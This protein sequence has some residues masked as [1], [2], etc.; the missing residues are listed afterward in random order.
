MASIETEIHSM[1]DALT[2]QL[3][4]AGVDDTRLDSIRAPIDGALKTRAEVRLFVGS[5]MHD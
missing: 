3:V 5:T 4:E 1:Q 2:P